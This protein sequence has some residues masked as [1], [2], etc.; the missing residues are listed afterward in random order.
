MP[1][2]TTECPSIWRLLIQWSCHVHK[3]M[4]KNTPCTWR[5]AIG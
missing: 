4:I 5:D 1:A 3:E 2:T